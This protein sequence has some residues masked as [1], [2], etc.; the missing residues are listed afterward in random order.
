MNTSL[1]IE[2]DKSKANNIVLSLTVIIL[3]PTVNY[4]ALWG[5]TNSM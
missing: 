1:V 5:S 2:M 3:Y 4:P